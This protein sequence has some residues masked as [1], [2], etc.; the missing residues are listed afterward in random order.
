ML[1]AGLILFAGHSAPVTS[2]NTTPTGIPPHSKAIALVGDLQRTSI[3]E[4]VMGRE[5]N[6]AE[7][8]LI[9]TSIAKENPAMVILLGDMV[10]DGSSVF[11]W[12]YFDTLTAPINKMDIKMYPVVGNHEY[13]GRT[14]SSLTL[15]NQRFP[16]LK[17]KSWYSRTYDSL[18]FVFLN[19]NSVELSSYDWNEQID[20]YN[21]T[22]YGFEN[23]PSIKGILVFTHH[24]P[25]TNSTVTGDAEDVKEAF[26]PAFV[27]STK[28]AAFFSGHAHTYE[29]FVINNKNFLISGGGGGPRVSLKVGSDCHDDLCKLDS[30]RPFNYVLVERNGNA[31]DV[32]VQALQK[33]TNRFYTLEEFP[34]P[35]EKETRIVTRAYYK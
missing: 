1:I 29:H 23:D 18:A 14:N 12:E 27:N 16:F 13:W 19:S 28:G 11:Q 2:K 22:M 7:R 33:G 30:P 5:Q 6:D 8:E 3:W 20:W 35:L 17:Q 31:L 34:I 9:I 15:L 25:Y 24:P 10:F 4:L 32:K 21:N 26:V